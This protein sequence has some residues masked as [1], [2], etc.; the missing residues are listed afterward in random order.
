M[1]YQLYYFYVQP[2]VIDVYLHKIKMNGR[3]YGLHFRKSNSGTNK[4]LGE[5]LVAPER[6]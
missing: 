2:A 6:Y 3:I 5:T 1:Y 4:V